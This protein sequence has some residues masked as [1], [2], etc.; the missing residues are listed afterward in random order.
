MRIERK[1]E[2]YDRDAHATRARVSITFEL[3]LR[4]GAF[5]ENV[6][7]FEK[8]AL[9][10]QKRVS[11]RHGALVDKV[12]REIVSPK[13]GNGCCL[14]SDLDAD[15][16]GFEIRPNDIV[17]LRKLFSFYDEGMECLPKTSCLLGL[18]KALAIRIGIL[19]GGELLYEFTLAE[20]DEE[21]A[22]PFMYIVK[23]HRRGWEPARLSSW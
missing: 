5:S 22:P 11:A 16:K 4:E 19:T 7:L 2:P 14:L 17:T 20:Y 21:T 10:F 23:A 8:E 3:G 1:V 15:E 6:E 13:G 9:E 18:A 12:A